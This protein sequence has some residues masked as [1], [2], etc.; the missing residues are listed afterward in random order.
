[1]QDIK[2]LY[3]LCQPIETKIGQLRFIKVQEYPEMMK[4]VQLLFVDKIDLLQFINKEYRKL[5]EQIS[6]LELIKKLNIEPIYMRKYFS[7]MFKFFFANDVF[8]LVQTDEELNYYRDL[9]KQ[10]NQIHY[11][12][13]CSNP[14]IEKFNIFKRLLQKKKGQDVTF[15]SI[16]T[17]VWVGTGMKPDDM[18]I[19]QLYAL[20]SR[21]SQFKNYDTTSLFATV[22]SEVRLSRGVN[23]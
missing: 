3:I 4:Y 19:Y 6:L 8:D 12:K 11:E 16:Y 23:I 7:E 14:E 22:T 5:I 9:I 20:F 15:E 13:P 17:S 18:C 21:I 1:M 10:M 2:D